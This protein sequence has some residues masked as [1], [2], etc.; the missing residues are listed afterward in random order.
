MKLL[1]AAAPLLPAL[2]PPPPPLAPLPPERLGLLRPLLDQ[3]PLAAGELPLRAV[4]AGT[5]RGAAWADDVTRP[6]AAL[7]SAS[8][9]CAYLIGDPQQRGLDLRLAASLEQQ[10]REDCRSIGGDTALITLF[11]TPWEWT[12]LRAIAHRRPSVDQWQYHRFEPERFARHL[13]SL[14]PLPPGYRLQR[15]DRELAGGA[16]WAT[17]S[18]F[19]P[20]VEAFMSQGQGQVL[21]GPDGRLLS[22]C[23]SCYADGGAHEVLVHTTDGGLRRLGLATQ[24]CS[25]YLRELLAA[26]QRPQWTALLSNPASLALARRL[27]FVPDYRLRNWEFVY[28][29]LRRAA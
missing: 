20:S 9:C 16:L 6:R 29:E 1:P 19:W 5:A 24:V 26:G 2:P 7:V 27:G 10:L 21:L 28:A 12:L 3:H 4:L 22:H 17:L 13:A 23:F 25:A 11:D 18:E 15:L 8:G 14:L